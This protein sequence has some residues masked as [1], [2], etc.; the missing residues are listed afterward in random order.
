MD[1]MKEIND[2]HGHL[3][4]DEA[5]CR[6]GRALHQLEELGI[7][8]VHISGDE[9]LAYGIVNGLDEARNLVSFVN[10]ELKRINQEDPWICDISASIG[11][12]AAIPQKN[13]NIDLFMTMA[14]RSM[15][16]DKNKRKY[17]RR[18]DDMR[19]DTATET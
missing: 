4:G 2:R 10:E 19:T 5:I 14:D 1:H 16:A 17:G 8:P 12:Y 11:V 13:D 7:T 3:M 6:M 18:K 9:F 15:Y